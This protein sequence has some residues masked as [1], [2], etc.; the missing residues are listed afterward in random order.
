MTVVSDT[1]PIIALQ[2]IRSLDLLSKLYGNEILIPPGVAD[3]LEDEGRMRVADHSFLRIVT[4]SSVL[5]MPPKLHR[6][7]REAIA[8]AASHPG[9]LLLMDERDGR[10]L[11]A[12]MGIVVIGTGGVLVDAKRAGLIPSGSPVLE[13]LIASG[14]RIAEPTRAALVRLAGEPE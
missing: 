1:S 14:F 5:E 13:A 6:G 7:E 11:A 9:C 3:E 8:L 4:N 2:R 10:R 12:T